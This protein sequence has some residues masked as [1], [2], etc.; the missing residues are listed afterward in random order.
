MHRKVLGLQETVPGK[1]H[2]YTPRS[3]NNLAGALSDR[4]NYEQVKEMHGQVFGLQ[5][6]VLGKEHPST[7]TT[8][9]PS[10]SLLLCNKRHNAEN[11]DRL[12]A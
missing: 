3:M 9:S 8:P 11:L 5:E 7:L 10:L 4:D 12:L 1:E 2:P 6:T